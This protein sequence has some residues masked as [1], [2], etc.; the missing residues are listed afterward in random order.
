MGEM[1]LEDLKRQNTEATEDVQEEIPEQQE[2]EDVQEPE[3]EVESE[4][5]EEAW[6]ASGEQ[7]PDERKFTGKDIKAAKENLRAKLERQ[8]NA[9]L[10]R[11]KAEFEALKRQQQPEQVKTTARPREEDFDYDQDKYVKALERWEDQRI[12]AKLAAEREKSARQAQIEQAKQALQQAEDEHYERAAKLVSE[13]GINQEAYK[14]ADLRFKSALERL[15]PGEGEIIAAQLVSI[16]GEGSEKLVYFLGQNPDKLSQLEAELIRDPTGMRAIA[17]ATR[18]TAEITLPKKRTSKAPEPPTQIKGDVSTGS[19]AR[20]L[21][22]K[23]EEA[24]K[25][26]NSQAAFD[27]RRE[28]RK[29]GV[30]TSKW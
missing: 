27:I 4:D 5:V 11:L 9:E 26:G 28:A 25:A 15:R 17:F 23:Y 29:S 21:K 20:A 3:S 16:V 14:S 2:A 1:T 18:T 7:T 13:H 19:A 8:H 22:K 6:K 12:S 10:E 30:D 24:S